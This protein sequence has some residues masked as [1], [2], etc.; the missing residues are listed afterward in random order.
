MNRDGWRQ[1]SEV[2]SDR[3][4]YNENDVYEPAVSACSKAIEGFSH[5][6]DFYRCSVC[7]QRHKYQMKKE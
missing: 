5:C 4:D 3:R 1:Y 6:K 2:F 7:N